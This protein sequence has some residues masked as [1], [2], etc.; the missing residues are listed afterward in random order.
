MQFDMFCSLG[1]NTVEFAYRLSKDA[2]ADPD[3]PTWLSIALFFL[4][5]PG[6]RE[7]WLEH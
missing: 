7:F 1:I 3:G 2:N 4:D 6:G 5:S